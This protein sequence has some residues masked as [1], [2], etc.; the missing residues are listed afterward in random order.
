QLAVGRDPG[1]V[2]LAVG[3]EA[4]AQS[5]AALLLEDELVVVETPRAPHPLGVLPALE[6]RPQRIDRGHLVAMDLLDREQ[7]LATIAVEA[8]PL[9]DEGVLD[10]RGDF[11]GDR[12]ESGG[13]RALLARVLAPGA[14]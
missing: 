9:A 1:R 12:V 3:A 13:K 2:E 11:R 14:A 8:V 10:E 7:H 5:V 6:T 4:V